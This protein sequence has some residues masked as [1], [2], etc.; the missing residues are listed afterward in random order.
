MTPDEGLVILIIAG[1]LFATGLFCL[2]A[3]SNLIKMV[4]GLEFLGKGVSLL[5]VLGG[6]SSGTTGE[7]QAVVFT[8]IAIEAVVAGLA[9]AL[10]IIA[11]RVWKTS[12]IAAISRLS[13]G[14][15]R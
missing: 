15:E 11:R 14:G 4:M 3:R 6:Y 2:I 12:D 8:L 1:A 9:L 5:F 7:S 10:V 13:P